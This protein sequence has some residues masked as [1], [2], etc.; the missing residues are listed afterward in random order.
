MILR[1]HRDKDGIRISPS[2]LLRGNIVDLVEADK[3]R[4]EMGQ[5]IA[6]QNRGAA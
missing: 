6:N 2:M 3:F 1:L 5:L 4:E